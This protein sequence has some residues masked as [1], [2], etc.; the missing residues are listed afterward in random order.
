MWKGNRGRERGRPVFSLLAESEERRL[1]LR[2]KG[3][4]REEGARPFLEGEG[5]GE[6]GEGKGSAA[7]KALLAFAAVSC[8][9]SATAAEV[10][11]QHH[12]VFD[13]V[14]MF[15][16]GA[17]ANS[18]PFGWLILATFIASSELLP[19]V[20]TQPF[21]LMSGLL[22]GATKGAMI[23]LLGT[24]TAGI[25]SSLLLFLSLPTP[26]Q[27]LTFPFFSSA[28]IAFSV[29][30]GPIGKK[31]RSFAMQMEREGGEG[32]IS[33]SPLMKKL[34]EGV[35]DLNLGQQMVSV[36]LLRFSPVVPFSIRY[37]IASLLLFLSLPTHARTHAHSFGE[38]KF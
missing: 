20:P 31:M 15:V 4:T 32:T 13:R 18:G 27:A 24:T 30:S 21:A 3:K 26:A 36:M 17:A 12:S 5:E 2:G 34:V 10:V 19:L 22:F 35:E 16:E 9:G 33:S 25:V 38:K 29:S 11:L 8:S 28:S 14:V 1:V 6:G 23:T 37:S 7:W